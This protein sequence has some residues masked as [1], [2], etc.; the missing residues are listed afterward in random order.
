MQG[1]RATVQSHSSLLSPWQHALLSHSPLSPAFWPF[2]LP[3]S[4]PEFLR[5][6]LSTVGQDQLGP[7][8]AELDQLGQVGN[9]AVFCFLGKAP[10]NSLD[11]VGPA[12]FPTMLRALLRFRKLEKAVAVSGILKFSGPN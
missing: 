3:L 7:N 10:L 11:Q 6:V 4:A 1:P 5:S 8:V 2:G 9:F 12:L